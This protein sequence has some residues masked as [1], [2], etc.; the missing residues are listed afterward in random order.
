[1]VITW[2]ERVPLW[3]AVISNGSRPNE[4]SEEGGRRETIVCGRGVC[5]S[6]E[7]RSKTSCAGGTTRGISGLDNGPGCRLGEGTNNAE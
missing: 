6:Q 4:T 7:L 2:S 3:M 5:R 1:M